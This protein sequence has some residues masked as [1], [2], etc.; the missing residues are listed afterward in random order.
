MSDLAF[1]LFTIII[2]GLVISGILFVLFGEVTV[3]RLRKNQQ[4]K[5]A[6]GVEFVS[7]ADTVNVAV[8]LSL[9]LSLYNRLFRRKNLYFTNAD[10][11]KICAFTSRLDRFIAR[12]FFW[13]YFI[14]VLALISAVILYSFKII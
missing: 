14:T 6:L 2:I 7:G 12:L 13:S 8:A 10:A 4:T 3:R 5:D 9:P 11:D 1:I